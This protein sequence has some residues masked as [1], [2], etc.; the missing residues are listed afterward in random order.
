M[1]ISQ[2]AVIPADLYHGKHFG[3]ILGFVN[4]GGGIGGFI[5]P[6]LAGYL[7][8]ISGNYQIAFAVSALAVMGGT[9]A[10]WIAAPRKAKQL[11]N[12]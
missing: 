11:L 4:G 1:R 12:T 7:F 8:D 6:P 10:V 5:G 3:T 9:I 2:L